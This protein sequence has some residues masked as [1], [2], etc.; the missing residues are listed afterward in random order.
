MTL[1]IPASE[2]RSRLTR[3]QS[4]LSAAELDLFIVS[5]VESIYY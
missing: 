1:R 5:S 3:L 4:S 2:Y